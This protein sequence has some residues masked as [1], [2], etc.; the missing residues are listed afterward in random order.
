MNELFNLSINNV[1]SIIFNHFLRP[2]YSKYVIEFENIVP[3]NDNVSLQMTVSDDDGSSFLASNYEWVST[4][5][6]S[7]GIQGINAA[8]GGAST[9]FILIDS[10]S[11]LTASAMNGKLSIGDMGNSAQYMQASG[12]LKCFAQ[13]GKLLD[14]SVSC[15]MSASLSINAIQ[16][17]MTSGNIASG[18][19][20]IYGVE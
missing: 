7:A 19:I 15:M 17:S 16:F 4:F 5:A 14:E 6:T 12:N 11:N 3:V 20:R 2:F 1:P 10:L 8:S 13:Y 18:T 9:S